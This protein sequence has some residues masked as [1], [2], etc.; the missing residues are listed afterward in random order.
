MI[1]LIDD[2]WFLID[3]M[4]CD[5]SW[6]FWIRWKNT[7]ST[8]IRISIELNSHCV[9]ER[10]LNISAELLRFHNSLNWRSWLRIAF[11]VSL[12]A[13]HLIQKISTTNFTII[14]K[15][16]SQLFLKVSLSRLME[17]SIMISTLHHSSAT[18]WFDVWAK[19]CLTEWDGTMMIQD[20]PL[21]FLKLS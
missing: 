15:W 14:N 3:W 2:W 16:L 5:W 1:C 12:I 18:L 11:R 8:L 21:M 13:I 9:I 4:I 17:T 19:L 7:L 20:V 10:W 6:N